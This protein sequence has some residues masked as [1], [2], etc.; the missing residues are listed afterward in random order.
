VKAVVAALVLLV[1]PLARAQGNR[2]EV[3]IGESVSVDVGN[4]VGWFCDDP[5]LISVAMVSAGN[6]NE[7]VATGVQVGVTNCRVGTELGR[8]TYLLEVHVLPVL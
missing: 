4:A 6:H 8:V 1:A 5:S 2:V 7:W 3:P